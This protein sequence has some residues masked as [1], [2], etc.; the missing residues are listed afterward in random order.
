METKHRTITKIILW[1]TIAIGITIAILQIVLENL[2][3]AV[4]IGLID[5]GT[6]LFIHYFY[7]R[8]WSKIGWGIIEKVDEDVV[9]SE[10]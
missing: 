5:H 3:K 9:A 6:C 8:G 1:Q 7:E 4:T 2:T 10:I